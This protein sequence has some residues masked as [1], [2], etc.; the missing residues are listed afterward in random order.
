MNN[1]KSFSLK[2]SFSNKNINKIRKNN[3]SD[4]SIKL[5]K[6]YLKYSLVILDNIFKKFTRKNI[7]TL[8]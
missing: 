4:F 3:K 6:K 5:M 7:Q 1:M 2:N 8:S